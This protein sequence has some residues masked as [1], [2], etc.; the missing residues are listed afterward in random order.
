MQFIRIAGH[1]GF[2]CYETELQERL[3]ALGVLTLAPP[4]EGKELCSQLPCG[5]PCLT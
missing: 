1:D 5:K 2:H 3:T 4:P